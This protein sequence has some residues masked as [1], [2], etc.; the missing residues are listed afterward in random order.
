MITLKI[1]RKIGK[2]LRG[3]AGRTEILLGT[4]CGV[5]IGF[6]PTLSFTLAAAILITLLLNANISFIVLGAALG[7][8]LSL[9]LAPVSFNTGY[10]IIHK[11]GLEE[12]FRSLCNA[13]VTALMD[14]NVYAMVGSLPYALAVGLIAGIALGSAIIRI[15]VKMLDANQHE[16]IGKTLGNKVS[17][18]LLWLAFGKSKLSLE[19]EIPKK[20]PLLRKSGLILVGA[21]IIIGLLMEFLLLDMFVKK[22]IQAS[23][24]SVTGAE[25]NIGD[26]HLSLAEGD[27]ELH[28]LQVTDPDRPTHNLA[29]LDTLA[30]DISIHDLLRK[31]Y[32][33]ELMEGS[34][35]KRNTLRASPGAVYAK[36]DV[37][38]KVPEEELPGKSL[39]DYFAKARDWEAYGKKAYNYLKDRKIKG[40]SAAKQQ[41]PEPSKEAALADAEKIGYLR[42][43][44]DLVADRPAWLIHKIRIDNVVL[45]EGLL[46]QVLQAMEVSSHP[47]LNGKPTIM[48]MAPAEAAVPTAKLVL[49]FDN[50]SASHALTLNLNDIPIGEKIETS[51]SFPLNIENGLADIKADGT[52]STDALSIPFALTVHHLEANVDEGQSIL[53]MDSATATE[54]FNSIDILEIDGSLDGTLLT[55]RVRI[56]YDKLT[57]NMKDALVAAGKKELANRANAEMDKAKE[58]LKNQ[59]GEE[60]NKLLGGEEGE[61]GEST[62]DKAKNALKKLF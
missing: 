22:S 7:K 53:G 20:S 42:A 61:E 8:V 24:A 29:Q 58:E 12:F 57:D 23:I 45:G 33:I 46:P 56:D 59:A 26:A 9:A 62:Q 30:L 5:L 28:D 36:P 21:V 41:R 34:T 48:E 14:L 47:E 16:I 10:F 6:N 37:E 38:E 15:R 31:T 50:P 32:V 35:L 49:R 2:I 44:A 17:R 40:Q 60:I 27:L 55:P 11:I 39:E 19:D 1:I 25:V 13:P 43:S 51:P 18:F 4:L 3:G 54:V 52:F